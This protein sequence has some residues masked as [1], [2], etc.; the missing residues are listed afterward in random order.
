MAAGELELT[1]QVGAGAS[2][3]RSDAQPSKVRLPGTTGIFA[4]GVLYNGK[5]SYGG[6]SGYSG[7]GGFG[8]S[9][10]VGGSNGNDGGKGDWPSLE[11]SYAGGS[12]TWEDITTYQLTEF[13]LSPGQGGQHYRH[14][15]GGYGYYYGGGGGGVLVGGSGPSRNQYQGE[16]Y[17]GG[18]GSNDGNT[19]GLPG[20]ILVEVV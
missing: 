9:G 6:G 20:V 4:P 16:G 3:S 19:N 11:E 8:E 5:N 15:N 2:R 13:T 7:G 1:A 12:G 17:G 18:D 10:G 14:P